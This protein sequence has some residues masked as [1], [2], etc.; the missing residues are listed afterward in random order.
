MLDPNQ[1]IRVASDVA[2][3]LL[4][5]KRSEA[6]KEHAPPDLGRLLGFDRAPEVTTLRRKL[7]TLPACVSPLT[8][9]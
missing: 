5:I 9:K 4:G 1:K 6:L 3:S 7:S 8:M 2:L